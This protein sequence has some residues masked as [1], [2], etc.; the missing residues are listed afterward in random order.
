MLDRNGNAV[1][2]K[3]DVLESLESEKT[4]TPKL[5]GA[6]PEKSTEPAQAAK[7]ADDS[8]AVT[9]NGDGKTED[10]AKPDKTSKGQQFNE[11]PYTFLSPT[12]PEV[13]SVAYVL[14]LPMFRS[15]R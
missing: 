9:V 6:E 14:V 4:K 10:T 8:S 11:E 5:E 13:I 12:D 3:A 15:S 7:T 2:R 1:K